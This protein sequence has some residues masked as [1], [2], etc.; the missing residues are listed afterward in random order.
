MPNLIIF[1]AVV[2]AVCG[3]VVAGVIVLVAYMYL[4]RSDKRKARRVETSLDVMLRDMG[5]MAKYVDGPPKS[6]PAAR[7]PFELGRAAMDAYEWDVAIRHFREAMKEAKGTELVVLLNLI[8]L[9]H[10]AS[11]RLDDALRNYEESADLA[12]QFGDKEGKAADL[13]NIGIM[14][15]A[16]GEPDKAL[17]YHEEVLAIHREIGY[18]QGV[19]NQLGN[20]GLIYRAKGEPDKAL[21]YLEEAL[22]IDRRIGY[23]PDVA[24]Q[25]GNIGSIYSAKGESD[26]A[27]EYFGEA[28]VIDRG[29]GYQQGVANQLGDIGLI[30]SAKGEPEKALKYYDEALVIDREIGDKHG[31]AN[32]LGK[33][34]LIYRAKGEPDRELMYCGEA[35]ASYREIGY[36]PGVAS[37]LGNIGNAYVWA[38]QRKTAGP[39]ASARNNQA[40]WLAE[41]AID[42]LVPALGMLLEMGIADG[43]RQ[44]LWGLGECYKAVGREDFVTLCVKAGMAKEQAE[45]LAE[46]RSKAT[47]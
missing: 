35:L 5:R 46:A 29:I 11:G 31:V 42:H 21:K 2:P 44:C 38:M 33:I 37:A 27:L 6:E 8:G 15:R 28:L 25:L 17:K 12:E 24:N 13:G 16:K 20:I 19:A 14:Y 18:Q 32:R 36:Q 3:A 23:Q 9:C 41:K 39:H 22:A 43:P 30:H 26:K 34:G 47:E 7:E 40:Y 4:L 45:G 1:W 10:Y